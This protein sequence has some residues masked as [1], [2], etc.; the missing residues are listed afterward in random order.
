LL[1]RHAMLHFSKQRR[2]RRDKSRR[3]DG[4]AGIR[5]SKE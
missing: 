1:L 4:K 2:N 3:R 5:R